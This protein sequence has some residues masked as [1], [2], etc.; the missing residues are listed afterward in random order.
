MNKRVYGIFDSSVEVISAINELKTIGYDGNEILLVTD[1]KDKWKFSSDVNVVMDEPHDESFMEKVKNFF[2]GESD[3]LTEGLIGMGLTRHNAAAYSDDVKDGKTLV[4]IDENSNISSGINHPIS[5]ERKN[6]PSGE[7]ITE[8][9]KLK[10][11][12]FHGTVRLGDIRGD[13]YNRR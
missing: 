13:E 9:S 12:E 7:I 1:K 3:S 2:T 6:G 5:T 10:D 4:L 11:P 8:P